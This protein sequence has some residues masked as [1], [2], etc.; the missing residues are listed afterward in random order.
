MKMNHTQ[1]ISAYY[2]AKKYSVEERISKAKR[3]SKLLYIMEEEGL[4]QVSLFD[5]Y[6]DEWDLLTFLLTD[7]Q[8]QQALYEG[9]GN[10]N[11]KRS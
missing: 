8:K 5:E 11:R 9:E 4:V 10:E 1:I 6:V 2:F 7:E 3:Y